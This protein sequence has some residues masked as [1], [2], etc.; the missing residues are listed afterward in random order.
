M[1]KAVILSLA[2]LF[3]AVCAAPVFADAGENLKEGLKTFVMSPKQIPDNIKEEYDNNDN[4]VLAVAGG[5]I[6]GIFYFGKDLIVGAARTLTF[7][8]DWDK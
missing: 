8:I 1:K 6:K 7:P 4:K 3:L 2:V 5:T